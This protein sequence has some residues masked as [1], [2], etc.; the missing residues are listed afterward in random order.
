MDSIGFI[1]KH[2]ECGGEIVKVEKKRPKCYF[3][4]WPKGSKTIIKQCSKCGQFPEKKDIVSV[5]PDEV[6]GWNPA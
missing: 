5:K 2:R 4:S 3:V 6:L 1:E